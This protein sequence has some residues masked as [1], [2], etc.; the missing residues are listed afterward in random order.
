MSSD[1]NGALSPAAVDA[2]AAVRR[3][4]EALVGRA[5][6]P[7]EAARLATTLAELAESVER[8]PQRTKVEA[9]A[10]TPGHDRV[11]HFVRTGRWPD[12][13]PDGAEVVF[14]AL[15]FVGGRLNPFS[16]D[17]TYHRDGEAAVGTATFSP[18]HEG[19]PDRV[20]GG[21]IAAVFDEV[22]GAVFRVRGMASSFTGT[23]TVRYLAPAPLGVQLEFRAWLSSTEGRKH[24]VEAVAS[25]PGGAVAEASGTF[26]QMSDEQFAQVI[27]TAASTDSN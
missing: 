5:M 16:A 22:M 8:F 9:F 27:E 26:I 11:S 24:Q 14:D 20:H 23:L 15:S 1:D 12:P 3:L 19:P 10:S 4:G 7:S 2:A 21:M 25:G 17:A 13:P 6:D 18:T